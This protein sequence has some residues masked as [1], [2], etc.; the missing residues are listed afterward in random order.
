MPRY[1]AIILES[2]ADAY[3]LIDSKFPKA[4]DELRGNVIIG[5]DTRP[6]C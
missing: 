2:I 6:S 3:K 4:T 1:N 5:W